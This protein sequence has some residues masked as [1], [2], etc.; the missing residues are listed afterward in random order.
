MIEYYLENP[1]YA[2]LLLVLIVITIFVCIKAGK[3]S[4]NR[5]KRNNE[6]MAKL[7]EENELR[8]EFAILTDDIIKNADAVRL[9]KGVALNLQKRVAD[10]TDMA[11]EFDSLEQWQKYVYALS[12]FFEDSESGMSNFFKM[13]TQPLTGTALR[14]MEV[15]IGGRLSEIFSEEF[16]QFDE[17]NENVSLDGN[18]IRILDKEA[19]S[20][21]NDEVIKTAGEYIRNELKK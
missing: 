21:I 13:N 17:E 12:I 20:L 9:F 5:G 3:A 15:I 8:N 16:G 10:K 2:A 1:K 11:A 14:G 18:R 6:I 4:I 19:E 7:K